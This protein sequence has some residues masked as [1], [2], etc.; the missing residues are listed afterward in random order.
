[1][2]VFKGLRTTRSCVF[3]CFDSF[4][5]RAEPPRLTVIMSAEKSTDRSFSM[6]TMP[7]EASTA[8]DSEKGEG[9]VA[10]S[11]RKCARHSQ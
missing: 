10:E 8:V 1:V 9:T 3:G 11:P 2:H 7:S 5:R 6:S 4:V